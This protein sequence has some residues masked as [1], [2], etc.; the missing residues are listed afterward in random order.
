MK[1]TF[2]FIILI[3]SFISWGQMPIANYYWVQFNTKSDTPY[4]LNEPETFLSQRSLERRYNKNIAID[5]TDL[6][7]NPLFTDSL[8]SLGFFVKHTSRWM[9][10]A[11]VSLNENI[12]I[13]SIIK[14]SFV[15]NYELR[16]NNLLKSQSNKFIEE[17]SLTQNFYGN[18]YNQIAMLNGHL[19]HQST[20]GEGVHV[21]V[22]DAGFKNSDILPAFDS[23]YARNG[24]LGTFDF[25]NPGN[26]V[27][28]EH[29]HGNAVLSIMAG[30]EPG[31]LIGSAPDASYWLLRSE[32]VSSE[33]PVEEDYWII[34][35]EFA[36]SVGCDVINTSLGYATF[37]NP[38]FDHTYDQFNGNTIR[39]S[40]A[41]NLAVD[42][43]IVV[44]ISAGNEGND[45]WGHIVA[46]SEA[47][48]VLSIAAVNSEREITRFSSPGFEG[49]GYLPKPD[50]AAMGS[51]VVFAS[52]YGGYVTG[53]G[54]SFSSPII[55]GMA[56]CLI[57]IYPDKSASEIIELIR[58]LGDRFPNH[59]LQYGYGIP[60]F[61]KVIEDLTSG[62]PDNY[63]S[64]YVN[65]RI[66]PNPF[67]IEIRI[68]NTKAI[69]QFEL[70]SI[71]GKKVFSTQI[72]A[73]RSEISSPTLSNLPKGVYFAVL[74]GNSII[75]TFK[76]MKH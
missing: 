32:D 67:T 9:N 74:K 15:D 3:S 60:D 42:K 52:E 72:Q 68:K 22:I 24:I 12:S 29:Y 47:E 50:V 53:G 64:D 37:D 6:P 56:A 5:S 66:Y 11:I 44:V 14:P 39:I 65:Y 36:D 40:Q 20:R 69:N 31:A 55:A 75:E 1:T 38:V 76:L 57:N 48:K 10:G 4:S 43:G 54:T 2:L 7:V 45:P 59:D 13:D 71:H 23:I 8:K 73:T 61:N 49:D 27:Y 17:D 26:N 16:K 51:D 70:Y 34:A 21:A 33:Y 46:P 58:S 25:V 30:I 35:A 63:R 19:I 62:I 18:S 28:N 41:A